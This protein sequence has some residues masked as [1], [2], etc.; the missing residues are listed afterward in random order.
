MKISKIMPVIAVSILVAVLIAGCGTKAPTTTTTYQDV[1]VV[2]G[3]ITNQITSTGTLEYANQENL[4][5][6]TNGTIAE[7]NVEVGDL[8]KKDDVLATLDTEE[9]A[10]QV[11]T[12]EKAIKAAQN[13]VTAAE[14]DIIKK[15]RVIAGKEMAVTDAELNLRTAENGLINITEIKEAK[16]AVDAVDL[17]I[18]IAEAN[19]LAA[20]AE[21]NPY[22]SPGG[23]TAVGYYTKLIASLKQDLADAQKNYQEVAAGVNVTSDVQLQIDKAKQQIQQ[24][25]KALADAKLAVEDAKTSVSDAEVAKSDA[26]LAVDDAQQALEEAKTANIVIKAPFNGVVITVSAAKGGNAKK[27]ATALVVADTA[28]FQASMLVNE[29]DIPSVSL[30]TQAT[31]EPSSMSG[32][33][34]SARVT[35]IAPVA[36]TQSGVVSYK[37]TAELAPLTNLQT[38]TATSTTPEQ[39]QAAQKRLDDA[40]SSAVTSGKITQEQADQLRTRLETMIVNLSDEQLNQMIQNAGQVPSGR[41]PGQGTGG[42]FLGQGVGGNLTQEQMDQLRQQFQSGG[43]SFTQRQTAATTTDIQLRQGLSLTVSLI[44]QQKQNVLVI[45]NAAVKTQSG[46]SSVQVRDSAGTMQQR[47]VTVGLK[48]YTNTEIVS[49]LSEGDVVV[50]T[51]TTTTATTGATSKPQ[52]G[53]GIGGGIMR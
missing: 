3:N 39:T 32:T 45:P 51:K 22:V 2:R 42:S 4:Y 34:L 29:M 37:V 49:G 24:S 47:E 50:I 15:Q 10:N 23:D 6:D 46:K 35:K 7:V 36:T 44:K 21:S 19:R 5:F 11:E 25:Q 14:N 40:L 53:F 41:V 9:R 12:L 52:Q 16:D 38:G 30:G 18:K 48:D 26:E 1:K 33:N 43:Q 20:G 28:R 31:I 17:K 13:V 8:F 27:G